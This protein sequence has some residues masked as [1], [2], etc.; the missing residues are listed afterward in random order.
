MTHVYE[1]GVRQCDFS[2]YVIISNISFLQYS[3]QGFEDCLILNRLLDKHDNNFGKCQSITLA[4]QSQRLQK[5]QR[6]NQNS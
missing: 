1:K 2:S 4:S 3:F 6:T 5:I